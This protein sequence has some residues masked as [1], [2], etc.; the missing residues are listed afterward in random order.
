MSVITIPSS[1]HNAAG[2]HGDLVLPF[3]DVLDFTAHRYE[4]IE[5]IIVS[6]VPYARFPEHHRGSDAAGGDDHDFRANLQVSPVFLI[7][8]PMALCRRR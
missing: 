8:T 2:G 1:A 3:P 7:S 4:G 5:E 6:G